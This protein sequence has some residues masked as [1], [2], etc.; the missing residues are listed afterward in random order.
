MWKW[1]VRDSSS[2]PRTFRFTP[3]GTASC[4]IIGGESRVNFQRGWLLRL[5]QLQLATCWTRGCAQAFTPH[6]GENLSITM[7][8]LMKHVACQESVWIEQK[9]RGEWW[10]KTLRWESIE[11]ENNWNP[12]GLSLFGWRVVKILVIWWP[13]C[14]IPVIW[15]GIVN[16]WVLLQAKVFLLF[17]GYHPRWCL[18]HLRVRNWPH[19]WN[20]VELM[21]W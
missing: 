7:P 15:N 5:I 11:F 17:R 19:W 6:W 21:G 14:W 16:C 13:R 20:Q 4:G 3:I 9:P 1:I 12:K 8:E 18:R 10:K 2:Y